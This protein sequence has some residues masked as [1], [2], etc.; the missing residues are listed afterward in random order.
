[1]SLVLVLVGLVSYD[2]L[3]GARI[4]GHRPAGRHRAD[5]LS[6]APARPSS[7]RQVTQVLED[8]LVG[9][10]GHR[11]HHLDQPAGIEPDHRALQARPR[12][13][14]RRGRR[15]RPGRAA[16]AAG[17]PT[18]STSRSSRRSR[19]TPS[20]SSISPSSAT[21]HSALEITDY[22]DRYVK[23]QLQTLPGVAEVRSV[24]RA[25]NI[26]CASGSIRSGSPPTA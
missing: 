24:R 18:R 10:R 19:P 12:S 11:L 21:A 20:R 25:R 26:P 17:C 16:C 9:H 1:M 6:R 8:S 15:A 2:R 22:A 13:R 14:L 4:S 5:D 23:D 7:R 3:V